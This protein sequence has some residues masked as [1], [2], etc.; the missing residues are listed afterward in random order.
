MKYI[1]LL[2]LLVISG[3]IQAENFTSGEVQY[4]RLY[5]NCDLNG[6]EY[7]DLGLPSGNIWA[8]S[9]YGASSPAGY[10]L[11]QEWYQCGNVS[12][13]WGAS[14]RTP[15]RSDMTEL[16]DYC[17]WNW[18]TQNG[19]NG[20]KVIG[21]NGNSIFLPAAGFKIIFG[22]EAQAL[23]EQ[24]YYW[25]TT[26]EETGFSYALTASSSFVST[27][28][29]YNSSIVLCP[30]RPCADK[31][32]SSVQ[33]T[34]ITLNQTNVTLEKGQ[35]FTLTATVL[36]ADATNKTVSWSTSNS[37]VATVND[38]LITAVSA[39]S[40]EIT[41]KTADGSNLSA[42]CKVAVTDTYSGSSDV[43]VLRIQFNDG[44][45]TDYTLNYVES[46]EFSEPEVFVP[47]A[48]D[49]GLPSGTKW[50]SCN[51]G[52]SK[53]EEYGDYYAW[54]ET[55]EKDLYSWNTYKWCIDSYFSITKYCIYDSFYGN[56]GFID[57][58]KELLP[59]DDA[60]KAYLGAP[61]HMPSFDQ[62]KELLD[63]CTRK[64]TIQNGVYGILVTGLN[65][66]TIF[67]PAA[68]YCENYTLYSENSSGI[69]WS[70]SL[71]TLE[72]SDAYYL[73]FHSSNWFW[74]HNWRCF[75]FPVRAVCP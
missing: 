57:G 7:V 69:Y 65:G 11:Y 17:T 48:I 64:W 33:A 27:S 42:T 25:T 8:T 14:W 71:Y 21:T 9:N 43:S 2:I 20:Y 62:I 60:A 47:E 12:S 73:G 75:G 45:Y 41:A 44:T 6:H 35:H 56:N 36:P 68:G 30:I 52:A 4:P 72:S 34:S 70:S 46:V 40:A 63:Y 28:Y 29:T 3:Q 22:G 50:A 15:S 37:S 54:G 55:E 19:V 67:L 1:L 24:L 39:G 32:S 31:V 23:G 18:T 74:Y 59:E 38:G 10:G 5:N 61:W 51:V 66:N 49:L 58:L 53:P 16:V 13:A 26:N